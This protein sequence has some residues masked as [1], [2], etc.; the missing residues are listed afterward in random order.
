M[1]QAEIAELF[2]RAAEVD[3]R[4]P[5]TARP[6]RLKSLSLP[7]VHTRSE[8]NEWGTE[9]LEEWRAEFWE[10][11]SR[12][13]QA[14]AVS[15]WEQAMD[16]IARVP[17]ESQ[18]RCL[19][20]WAIAK[21]GG[22]P[23]AIWCR[24]VEHIHE[25]TGTRRKDRAIAHIAHCTL[26]KGLQNNE[27]VDFDVLPVGPDLGDIA[28]NVA[29]E[30]PRSFWHADDAF[31]PAFIPELRDMTWAEMKNER[32]RQREAARRKREAAAQVRQAA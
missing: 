15:E 8:M 23:F 11:R 4:L 3:R 16:L 26:R 10:E 1:T 13:L 22:L 32:R 25:M 7:I 21:A 17:D 14:S 5:D 9:R 28:A 6:A 12:Q 29:V 27:N 31:R 30:R 20:H 18:R 2:I 24:R 19:W